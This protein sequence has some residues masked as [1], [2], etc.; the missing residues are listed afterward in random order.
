MKDLAA[1]LR[2]LCMELDNKYDVNSG[3]CMYAAYMIAKNLKRLSIYY[4]VIMWYDAFDEPYHVSIKIGNYDTNPGH[5]FL[6][7]SKKNIGFMEPKKINQFTKE[8]EEFDWLW[9]RQN[10]KNVRDE[11]NSFFRLYSKPIVYK[12]T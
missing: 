9:G 1:A 5:Y 12:A 2:K 6:H 3:G 8:H 11:I 10:K 7:K 4:N